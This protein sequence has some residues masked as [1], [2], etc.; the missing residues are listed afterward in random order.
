[1]GK[2]MGACRCGYVERPR[3]LKQ[4]DIP[5]W[6]YFIEAQPLQ[7]HIMWCTTNVSALSLPTFIHAN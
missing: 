4:F 6:N 2:K 7:D 3:T 5:T 1:M